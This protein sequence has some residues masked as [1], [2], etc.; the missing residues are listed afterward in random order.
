MI[1]KIKEIKQKIGDDRVISFV[2][3]N[4]NILHIGHQRL[5]RFAKEKIAITSITAM[6]TEEISLKPILLYHIYGPP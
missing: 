2:S 4:F 5:L 3:G 1:E 6:P